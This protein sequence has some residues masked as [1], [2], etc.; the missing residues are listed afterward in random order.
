[1]FADR[2]MLSYERLYQA[3]DSD[4]CRHP[5]P[6]SGLSLRTF[7]EEWGKDSRPQR[8]E[9]LHRKTNRVN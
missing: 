8:G 1:M 4:R 5:Q 7:M 3:A 9:E 2:S 6:N